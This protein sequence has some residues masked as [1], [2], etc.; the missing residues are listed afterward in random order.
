MKI[1]VIGRVEERS[2]APLGEA[3]LGQIGLDEWLR[4]AH[5]GAGSRIP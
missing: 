4:R 2:L 1:V 3:R 5:A